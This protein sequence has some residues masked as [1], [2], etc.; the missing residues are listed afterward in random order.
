MDERNGSIAFEAVTQ[1]IQASTD[2]HG[3]WAGIS[4]QRIDNSKRRFHR[5][6]RDTGFEVSGT[7]VHNCGACCL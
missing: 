4:V 2:M 7:D 3:G 5:A 1:N 6:V